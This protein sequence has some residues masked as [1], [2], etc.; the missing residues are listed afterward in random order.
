MTTRPIVVGYDG[1]DGARAALHWAL[2]E[3]DRT[4]APV[5]LVYAFE[6]FAGPV[7]IS[8]GPTSWPDTEARNAVQ[9]MLAAAVDRAHESHPAVVVT[10][11]VVDG[12]A[13]Q[14]LQDAS[15]SA[16][17]VV[18]GN[19]GLGGFTELLIGSTAV[20][21]SAT[22]H[23][24]VIV[25]RGAGRPD[26]RIVAG[27][28]GSK[29]SQVALG[30]AFEQ[31]AARRVALHVVKTW[32]SPAQQFVLP[33]MDLA[34]VTRVAQAGLDLL[35]N[36]WRNKYPD[37]EVT[38]EVLD[39]AAAPTLIETG[40]NSQLVVVGSRGRGGLRGMLLGS[41]SQQLIHHSEVP[42]A[43]VREL[44]AQTDTGRC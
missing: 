2:D 37:V 22:A 35:V 26:G 40:R 12:P 6:W 27:V 30:W 8:P 17:M 20:A 13:G 3:A 41:V 21:V 36:E 39:A 42:V 4:S 28:D 5:R 44:S 14:R 24:P 7:W 1:S 23:C 16:S 29:C 33:D 9:G 18:V 34:E 15:A 32:L 19:R 25:V 31:A 11:S 38:T 43:I 10:T